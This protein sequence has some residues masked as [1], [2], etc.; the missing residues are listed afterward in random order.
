MP[1][2]PCRSR[3]TARTRRRAVSAMR[4]RASAGIS[5]AARMRATAS[6]SSRRMAARTAARSGHAEGGGVAKTRSM[7]RTL[8]RTRAPIFSSFS[9]IVPQLA[10][11]NWVC[12]RPMRRS[13]HEQHIGERGKPQPQLVGPHGRGRGAVGEQIELAL[14]DAVLHL[15]A[16]AID[17]LVE[18]PG[19]ELLE[20]QR[21]DHK[22]W[23]GFAAGPLGLGDDA[24]LAAPAR[25]ASSR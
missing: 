7:R 14:L 25:R 18:V 16:R 15:A 1:P 11:A 19:L 21:G 20:R 3:R 4:S 5:A 8:M 10:R 12:A 13:A 22:A 24:A 17:L 23:I 6:V 2:L 9:R